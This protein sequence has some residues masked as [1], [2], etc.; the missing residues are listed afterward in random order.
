MTVSGENIRLSSQT[1]IQRPIDA[2]STSVPN[3]PACEFLRLHTLEDW[4]HHRFAGHG[5]FKGIGWSHP[6]LAGLPDACLT[7]SSASPV[8]ESVDLGGGGRI[9]VA[10]LAGGKQE[11]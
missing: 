4:K 9:K 6:E 8:A 11:P 10:G 3:C 5:Y 7:C 1:H 2:H